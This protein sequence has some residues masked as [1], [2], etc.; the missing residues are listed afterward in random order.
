[1]E[2]KRNLT[3]QEWIDRDVNIDLLREN[4]IS[5]LNEAINDESIEDVSYQA[6]V[7][8]IVDSH[9]GVYILPFALEY[10]GFDID[11]SQLDQYIEHG[12]DLQWDLDAF[13]NELADLLNEKLN[14]H[15]KVYFGY[16][17]ADG[18]YALMAYIDKDIYENHGIEGDN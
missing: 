12:E 8:Y 10:F 15:G 1:M 9:H 14:L 18:S 16:S 17:D 7:I 11:S 13:V 6:W 4:I 3:P 5:S 2:V